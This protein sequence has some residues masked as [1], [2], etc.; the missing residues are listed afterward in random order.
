M[1]CAHAEFRVLHSVDGVIVSPV[2]E[3]Y[4]KLESGSVWRKIGVVEAHRLDHAAALC[5]RPAIPS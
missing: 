1:Y 4:S 2:I 3:R 5:K